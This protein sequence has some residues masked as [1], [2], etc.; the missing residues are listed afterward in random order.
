MTQLTFFTDFLK[1]LAS[2]IEAMCVSEPQSK[3][4]I[5]RAIWNLTSSITLAAQNNCQAD[6]PVKRNDMD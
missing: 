2:Y 3:K 4:D 6:P 5:D 1:E